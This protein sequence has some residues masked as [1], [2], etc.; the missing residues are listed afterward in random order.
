[1]PRNILYV[2]LSCK[3]CVTHAVAAAGNASQNGLYSIFI[4]AATAIRILFFF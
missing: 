3:Q 2:C 1:M 4:I